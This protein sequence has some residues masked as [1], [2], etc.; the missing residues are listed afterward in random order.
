MPK[1]SVKNEKKALK[2]ANSKLFFPTFSTRFKSYPEK[3]NP[4]LSQR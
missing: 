4:K 2:N 3:I 1:F